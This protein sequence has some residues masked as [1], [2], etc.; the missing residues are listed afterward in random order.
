MAARPEDIETLKMILEVLGDEYIITNKQANDYLVKNRHDVLTAYDDI[1]LQHELQRL[2]K[3]KPPLKKK[4][5]PSPSSVIEGLDELESAI[6]RS[7]EDEPNEGREADQ[8][9]F[10]VWINEFSQVNP[11]RAKLL[12]LFYQGGWT[13][14]NPRGDGFCGLYIAAIDFQNNHAR[15]TDPLLLDRVL[16]VERDG[17]IE[18]IIDGMKK[19]YEARDRHNELGIR[20]PDELGDNMYINIDDNDPTSYFLL[21]Q[22][23]L[24]T[25]EE[26]IRTK[27][28]ILERLANTPESVF[29]YLPYIYKRSYLILTYDSFRN[30][31]PFLTTFMP[32]YADVVIDALG[33]AFYPYNDF[34][35]SAVMFN[36]GHYFLLN[37]PNSAIKA[38]FVNE[39]IANKLSDVP[40]RLWQVRY[41]MGKRIRKRKVGTQKGRKHKPR[42]YKPIRHKPRTHKPIK[43]K[44]RTHKPRT[45]KLRTHKVKK[46]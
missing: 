34:T 12:D 21:T 38:Q 41:A 15:N 4:K 8:K 13:V 1:I 18:L 5:L 35:N 44:P 40:I 11:V 6:L 23:L 45:H 33:N 24:L 43:H 37:N 9:P 27:L 26:F 28:R 14:V 32:C 2:E 42:T 46:Q 3:Q 36:D 19:Y 30:A 20:I 16:Q 31:S 17:L 7:L 29:R 22:E 39:I 25:N 10:E